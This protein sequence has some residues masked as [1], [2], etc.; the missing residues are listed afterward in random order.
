MAHHCADPDD[1]ACEQLNHTTPGAGGGAVVGLQGLV[2][3]F[4]LPQG[5][6]LQWL[7]AIVAAATVFAFTWWASADLRSALAR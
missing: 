7:A 6:A 1:V 4:G 5:L 2:W 3:A